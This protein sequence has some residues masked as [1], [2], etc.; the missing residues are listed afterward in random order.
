MKKQVLMTVM[1]LAVA[2]IAH[3]S[4]PAQDTAAAG[5]SRV[6]SSR[7]STGQGGIV[8]FI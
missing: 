4:E 2:G 7:D 8:T 6:R 3:A 5:A 1:V